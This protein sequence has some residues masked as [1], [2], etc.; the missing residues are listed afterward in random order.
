MTDSAASQNEVLAFLGDARTHGGRSV[1]R[2]DTHAAIVFLAG[3]RALKVKRAVRF[4]FLDYSTLDKRHAACQA[5]LEV[6]RHFAP[7]LY[8][9]V[10]P[11]TRA[12]DGRLMLDGEGEPVEWAV[13]MRRFDE[14]QTLDRLAEDGRLDEALADRLAR[15]VAAMHARAPAADFEAWLGKIGEILGQNAVAFRELPKLFPAKDVESL[16]AAT[17]AAFDRVRPLLEARGHTGLVRRG[18]GDLHLGNIALI[19]GRP[20]PFDAIEF[21][22]LIAAGDLLYDLAFLL[23]DL[24]ERRLS[25]FANLVLN[26]YLL[27]T[28]RPE[29]LPGLAAL[30]LFMSLRASIRAK[31]TAARIEHVSKAQRAKRAQTAKVYFGLAARLL[32]PAEPMLVAIGGLSGT[33]KSALARALAPFLMPEPGA[34]VVRSDVER[35]ILFGADEMQRLPPEAYHADVNAKVYERISD[36]AGRTLAARHSA[37]ADAVYGRGSER[38]AIE[39]VATRADVPFCGLFLVADLDVRLQRIGGR[40]GDASDAD[41]AVA[42]QQEQWSLDEIEWKRIDASGTQEETLAKARAAL[43]R[44]QDK[45]RDGG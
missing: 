13:D 27:E 22:P 34:V 24:V 26:R 40:A 36:K 15:A 30:P 1:R 19:D 28:G 41:A 8:R 4:P 45:T 35:K 17:R 21:D 14:T 2:I 39:A 32:S 25:G 9:R 18:H 12:P 11:I 20:L 10:V 37:V 38:A 16:V 23:M 44:R 31:V 6:N 3:A 7:E 42:R 29:D 43:A 5:E 33:G